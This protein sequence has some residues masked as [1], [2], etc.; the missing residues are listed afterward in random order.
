[1][2]RRILSDGIRS[3]AYCLCC[4]SI[5]YEN[6]PDNNGNGEGGNSNNNNQGVGGLEILLGTLTRHHLE[7]WMA[8]CNK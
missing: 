3:F 4:I 8:K 5:Y 2:A 1:M 6:G 7:I